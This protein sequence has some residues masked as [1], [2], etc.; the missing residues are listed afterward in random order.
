MTRTI[1]TVVVALAVAPFMADALTSAWGL[2]AQPGRMTPLEAAADVA[3]AAL[4]LLLAVV[5]LRGVERPPRP[6][7]WLLDR[8]LLTHRL[9]EA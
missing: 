9:P 2:A 7:L 6:M 5:V 4:A 1:A 3:Q 8:R